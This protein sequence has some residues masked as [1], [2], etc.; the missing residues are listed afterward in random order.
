MDKLLAFGW[1]T[2]ILISCNSET[3]FTADNSTEIKSEN[4]SF[5]EIYLDSILETDI[6][7]GVSFSFQFDLD[8]SRHNLAGFKIYDKG[9]LIQNITYEGY[10]F[11]EYDLIDWN[12][13]G[14]KDI[15]VLDNCGS[16]GC[17]YFIW[18]Y[19]P[20]ENRFKLNHELSDRLGLERDSVNQL[21]MF[22]YRAGY[23]EELWSIKKYKGD[24][25]IPLSNRFR[26]RWI[27][28]LG[29]EWEK[30]TSRE[31]KN[32]EWVVQVDSFITN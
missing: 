4:S 11:Y 13:D 16:G 31:L 2:F 30:N 3:E 20:K 6:G 10:S 21:I 25:L 9:E 12:F 5:D 26:E 8:S 27:D 24:T 1:I 14:Y 19:F 29:N 7:E 17:T 15:S 23:T 32:D 22:H 28:T 18:N